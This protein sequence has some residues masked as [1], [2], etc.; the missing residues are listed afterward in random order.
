MIEGPVEERRMIFTG[1]H[2]AFFTYIKLALFAALF[3]S[4]PVI[5]N[6]VWK[7]LAPGLYAHERR[8]LFPA[9]FATP[10][11]FLAGAA[12]AFYVVFPL[13]WTFFLSFE[14]PGTS[15]TLP[16]E[17]EAR[18][19]E[20]LSLVVRLIFAFG[21]GFQLPVVLL[22]LAKVGVVTAGGLR[23]YRRHAIVLTFIGAALVTPP[24][25][26]SQIALGVPVVLL[27]ELAIF[28]IQRTEADREGKQRAAMRNS[29][30]A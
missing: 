12:L 17:L 10:A 11:L 20:Y 24:D 29:K 2:E 14:N 16:I 21:L 30:I 4:L 8:S 1:L 13:A 25:L 18:V 5:L 26:V 7:F 6:Q 3:V 28:L 9:F 15:S 27:Y 23:E 19:S 22:V